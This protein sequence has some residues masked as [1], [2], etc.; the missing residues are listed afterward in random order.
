M[1]GW[2]ADYKELP[3]NIADTADAFEGASDTVNYKT[4][5]Q[6]D[7]GRRM[8]RRTNVAMMR[9]N[10][11]SAKQMC[12]QFETQMS[13]AIAKRDLAAD[14]REKLYEKLELIAQQDTANKQINLAIAYAEEIYTY[15]DNQAKKKQ[16]GIFEELNGIIA[17]NFERMFNDGEKY[18]RLEDDYRVHVYY[19][20]IGGQKGREETNLSNGEATAINFVYIVSILE[21]A[22]RRADAS[23]DTENTTNEGIISLPL[24]LDGPFS[25]LSNENTNLV[26]Q[27]LPEFAEQVIIFML[28]K[29]WEASGLDEYTLPGYCVHINK[30]AKS[31]SSSFT[32]GGAD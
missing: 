13:N 17:E 15:A 5:E 27:K 1:K 26:A 32:T 10:F 14:N 12:R 8:D 7:L 3:L 20:D 28:D 29:D 18:A 16:A 11:E 24:V 19:R 23:R 6:T 22:R 31:N 9:R 25:S 2:G 30:E 21:L 4:D